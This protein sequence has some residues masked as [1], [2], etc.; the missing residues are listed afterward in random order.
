ME[1]S[2]I[3]RV[4]MVTLLLA[5]FLLLTLFWAYFTS[6]ILAL[7]IASTFYPLYTRLSRFLGGRERISALLVVILVLFVLIIPVGSLLGSLSTEAMGLYAKAKTSV[8]I[9]KIQDAIRSDSPWAHQF[10]K[11][12]K[13]LGLE[14]TADSVERLATSLAGSVGHYLSRQ[15][16]SIGSNLMSFLVHFFLM[17][18]IIYYIFRDGVRLRSYISELLPFP[19]EQQDLVMTRFR[20][21]AKA[22]LFGNGVNALL[23]GVLGGLGFLI[24]NLGSPVLWGT[25]I[26]FAALLPVVG[27]SIVFIPAAAVLLVQ[28]KTGTAIAFLVYN[29]CYSLLLE[30]VLKPRLIGK[31]IHMN[32]LL[33]FIGILGGLKMFGILGIIYGPL[34][35]TVFFTLADIYRL[36]YRD[37]LP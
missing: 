9:K 18:L 35:M 5:F 32:S 4:F 28:G 23:Q 27:S 10:R 2:A 16:G 37:A 34:I 20:L 36:E 1:R 12:Q 6:I 3:A 17:I 24:F 25:F 14:L 19:R 31:E 30:N 29:A 33:V 26:A 15:I 7:I 11:A 8:S 13:L 21:T 22:V